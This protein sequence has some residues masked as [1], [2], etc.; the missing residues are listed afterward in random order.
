MAE[1]KSRVVALDGGINFRDLGGYTNRHGRRV[2]WRKIMRCGHLASLSDSDLDILEQIGISKVHDFR[3]EEEQVQSP[4]SAIRAEFIDDYQILIGDIS[5]FWEFLFEGELTAE[6]SHQ[7][8]VNSYRSCIDS[9]IPAFSRFMRHIVDNADNASL[10][11]CSA[12]KD[13]TGMAAALILAALDV[14]RE[15]IIQDYMLTLEHYNS[16]KLIAIVE[17]HL[18][19]AEVESWDR[20]WLM[21]YCSV[22]QDNIVAFLDAIEERYG[23]VK[24]Y[25]VSALELSPEDL[26]KMH[27]CYLED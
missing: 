17:E 22:H 19:R 14:P 9:V 20:E 18:R 27:N 5:R 21:P 8:V 12:G 25:L 11:H 7:L 6:S 15:T 4:S 10:F 23:D 13:R 3:R 1:S 16:D 2:K 26:E 24:N